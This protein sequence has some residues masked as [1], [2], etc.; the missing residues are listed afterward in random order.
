MGVDD[1][2]VERLVPEIV[3]DL[4]Q[5]DAFFQEVS[6]VRMSQ[7]IPILHMNGMD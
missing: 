4:P 5:T 7:R 3:A 6:G 2:G 1:G